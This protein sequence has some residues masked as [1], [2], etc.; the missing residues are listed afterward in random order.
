MGSSGEGHRCPRE[1][2]WVEREEERSRPIP[3]CD[4]NSRAGWLQQVGG[5]KA[6]G[7]EGSRVVDEV[8]GAEGGVSGFGGKRRD[9]G[10]AGMTGK[11][12]VRV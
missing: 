3:W 9:G 6:L 8:S 7:G 12:G 2:G 5:E 11:E 10:Q 4:Y 1:A